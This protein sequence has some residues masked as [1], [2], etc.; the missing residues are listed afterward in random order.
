M[1]MCH[2]ASCSVL[3][4][5]SILEFYEH[6]FKIHVTRQE[7]MDVLFPIRRIRTPTYIY[8]HKPANTKTKCT[9]AECEQKH[10]YQ[11]KVVESSKHRILDGGNDPGS[12][13]HTSPSRSTA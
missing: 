4:V 3:I 8:I 10:W 5:V 9:Q 6:D 13:G 1:P 2:S 7:G 11:R 12:V